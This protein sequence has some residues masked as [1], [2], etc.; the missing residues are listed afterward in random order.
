MNTISAFPRRARILLLVSLCLLLG[1]L[2]LVAAINFRRK[3]DWK[4]LAWAEHLQRFPPWLDFVVIQR[5]GY[6]DLD[7]RTTILYANLSLAANCL[8]CCISYDPG[9]LLVS[10]CDAVLEDAA[11]RNS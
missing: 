9:A 1:V 7:H 3:L 10:D 11:Y 2:P 4:A 5:L 6:D 8:S